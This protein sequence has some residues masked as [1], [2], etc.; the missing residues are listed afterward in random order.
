MKGLQCR[1]SRATPLDD[2]EKGVWRCFEIARRGVAIVK[3]TEGYL[4]LEACFLP[5]CG[6]RNVDV[7]TRFK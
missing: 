2:D 6:V 1:V 5:K 7:T 3:G 4:H